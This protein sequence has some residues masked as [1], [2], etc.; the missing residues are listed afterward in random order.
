MNRPLETWK[1]CVLSLLFGAPIGYWLASSPSATHS[2][3]YAQQVTDAQS[4]KSGLE[5]SA[6]VA[7]ADQLSKVFRDV[8]KSLKPSVVSIKN[9][10]EQRVRVGRSRG[11][12]NL[13][14]ELEQFFGPLP[15][16]CPCV[17]LLRPPR[18]HVEG[19][20]LP[21]R[22]VGQLPPGM[23]AAV[24]PAQAPLDH[25]AEGGEGAQHRHALP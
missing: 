24:G 8:S 6:S 23:S 22:P 16:G 21:G 14:P 15:V 10:V 2:P 20:R 7:S 18:G 25:G 17:H 12:L 11:N 4:A 5:L 19:A 1:L 3:V 9:I 13:P